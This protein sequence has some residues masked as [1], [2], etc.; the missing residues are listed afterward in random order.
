MGL[1]CNHASKP[2]YKKRPSGGDLHPKYAHML[3]GLVYSDVMSGQHD[4]WRVHAGLC[5]G[6]QSAA[7]GGKT[8]YPSLQIV[9]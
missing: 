3:F 4:T 7:K 9:F 5:V 8:T 1:S 2:T 6:L